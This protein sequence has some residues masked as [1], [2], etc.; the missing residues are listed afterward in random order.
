MKSTIQ[1]LATL[2]FGIPLLVACNSSG[3]GDNSDPSIVLVHPSVTIEPFDINDEIE[4]DLRVFVVVDDP[5]GYSDIQSATVRFPGGQSYDIDLTERLYEHN[6]QTGFNANFGLYDVPEG[7]NGKELLMTGYS[8]TLTDK[9][10]LSD[11]VEFDLLGID[12]ATV[13]MG[14]YLVHPDDYP[15]SSGGDYVEGIRRP[16][17]GYN[18]IAVSTTDISMDISINDDRAFD[19]TIQLYDVSDDFIARVYITGPENLTLEGEASYSIPLDDFSFI[20]G[21]G[22]SD[23]DAVKVFTGDEGLYKTGFTAGVSHNLAESLMYS[24]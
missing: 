12:G 1:P 21:K 14:A 5:D 19:L 17:V 18:S 13:P 8:L 6:G 4:M 16:I 7:S 22:I 10:G 15:V 23:I 2:V 24:L 9:G 20:E 11:E 3:G